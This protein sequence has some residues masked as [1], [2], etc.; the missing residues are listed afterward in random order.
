MK[1]WRKF[2]MLALMAW[3]L[4]FLCLLSYY[5]DKGPVGQM[6]RSV[7]ALARN[8]VRRL[9]SFQ[10]GGKGPL[11]GTGSTLEAGEE[12]EETEEAKEMRRK[13]QQLLVLGLWQGRASSRLLSPRLQQARLHYLNSNKHQVTWRPA[14]GRPGG[15][16]SSQELLCELQRRASLRTLDGSQQPFAGMG[17]SGV[18]PGEPLGPMA[19]GS[20]I[21]TCAVVMSAGAM[22]N[23]SLGAEIDSHDA[24]LR[25]NA[26]P[27]EGY[28][29]DVGNK[30]TIRIMNSQIL[31]RP[32]F[33]FNSSSL[34]RD[35]TLVWYE[36]PDFDFFTPYVDRRRKR[37]DQ[38]FYI[39][40]PAFLWGLWDVIQSNSEETIQPNPPSSGFIGI[41][42]ML[43][44]CR[45]VHV[46]E[47]IPS[48]RQTDLCHYFE[49][50][51][52]AA[53][54][55]GAYHPLLYEKLLVQRMSASTTPDDLHQGSRVTL[56]GF[57]TVDCGGGGIAAPSA[58]P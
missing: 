6:V 41:A 46:Y 51:I 28:E 32:M 52:N 25:F 23:S 33:H 4:L 21:E 29:K 53:C 40:H 14:E 44:L 42:V 27:T 47:Y 17:W 20:E 48:S 30:T 37:P 9:A 35:G 15:Q 2:L 50:H 31:A 11:V 49:P 13:E 55:L 36:D 22:L 19:P 57:S 56:P 10:A 38:P 58:T 3:L 18:V 39:L 26:A 16:R 43:A 54:T 45:Q 1:P 7:G 12:E 5:L 8:E 24:V 34:Y